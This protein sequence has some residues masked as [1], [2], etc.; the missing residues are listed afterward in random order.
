MQPTH[1]TSIALARHFLIV[2]GDSQIGSALAAHLRHQGARV[3]VTTRRRESVN[4][5]RIFL[6]LAANVDDFSLPHDIDH[7]FL[8]V[9]ISSLLGCNR[10]PAGSAYVNVTAVCH[11][12]SQLQEFGTHVL[13]LSSNQVFDGSIATPT[14]E[15]PVSPVNEYGR[16]KAVAE[17][18]LISRN[19]TRT[20][21]LRTTKVIGPHSPLLD[22]WANSLLQ[23]TVIHPFYNMYLS[24]VPLNVIVT[25]LCRMALERTTGIVQLSANRDLSYAEVATIGAHMLGADERLV[26]PISSFDRVSD[27]LTYP[28]KTALDTTRLQADLR[29]APPKAVSVIE[30]YFLNLRTRIALC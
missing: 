30:E 18:Q 29:L 22:G 5:E 12:A 21:I 4:A 13:L 10:D 26:K 25:A 15:M 27:G 20:A 3:I 24:P 19:R 8:C 9:G 2:G 6:D 11:I 16:Q 17:R 23:G 1:Q 7:A 28:S 14:P